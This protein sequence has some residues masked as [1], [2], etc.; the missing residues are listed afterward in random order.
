M[1]V[2]PEMQAAAQRLSEQ[3]VS[4]EE[5]E[6]RL[7]AMQNLSVLPEGL[8]VPTLQQVLRQSSDKRERLRAVAILQQLGAQGDP[9]SQIESILR[10]AASDADE[11]VAAI[12]RDAWEHLSRR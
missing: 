1:A 10:D 5:S 12:A 8:A 11:H 6:D 2:T 7:N 4:A 9:D 3:A